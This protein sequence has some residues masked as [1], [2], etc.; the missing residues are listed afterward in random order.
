MSGISFAYRLPGNNPVPLKREYRLGPSLSG[1]ASL[2]PGSFTVLDSGDVYK[3]STGSLATLRKLL[4]ADK[5]AEYEVSTVDAGILGLV[6]DGYTTDSAG[7]VNGSPLLPSGGVI[8]NVPNEAAASKVDPYTGHSM[9]N[10]I[11]ATPDTVFRG[12]INI[13]TTDWT[14]GTALG[15]QLDGRRFGLIITASGNDLIYSIDLTPASAE[16][17]ILEVLG[18]DEGDPLYN[19]AVTGT[20]TA[21]NNVVA[22][23]TEGPHVFFRLLE[24]FCQSLTNLNYDT[25]A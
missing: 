11:V 8:L 17:E 20:D 21:A 2:Y 25:D 5:T 22:D 12:R 18:P 13:N 14:G 10:V 4:A 23:A 9:A 19:K 3:T 24:G 16:F 7:V 6:T 15:H 1:S